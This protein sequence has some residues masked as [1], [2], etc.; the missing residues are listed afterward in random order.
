MEIVAVSFTYFFPR[1]IKSLGRTK[2]IP[3]RKLNSLRGI[4]SIPP[5]KIKFLGKKF[6]NPWKEI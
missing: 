6:L 1:E 3:P 5:K 4:G 2:R